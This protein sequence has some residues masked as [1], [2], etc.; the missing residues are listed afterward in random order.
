MAKRGLPSDMNK[1]LKHPNKAAVRRSKAARKSGGI[2]KWGGVLVAIGL[3]GYCINQTSGV[4]Y[5]EDDIL[6]VDFSSLTDTQKRTALREANAA[7]CTC[8]CG[9]T[10]AQCVSTDMTCPVRTPNIERIKT[11]VQNANRP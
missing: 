9:M 11:I 7:R 2:L 5:G 4:A 3:M 10:L 6:V 8:G 1:S